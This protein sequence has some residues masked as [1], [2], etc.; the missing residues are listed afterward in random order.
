MEHVPGAITVT[1][2]PDTLQMERVADVKLTARLELAVALTENGATPR[3]TLLSGANVMV[4]GIWLMLKLCVT[5]AAAAYVAFPAWLATMVQVPTATI[6][7]VLP[8]IVQ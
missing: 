2:F 4:C 5:V 6:V 8:A 1:V 7:T 3:F